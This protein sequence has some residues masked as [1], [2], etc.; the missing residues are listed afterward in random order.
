MMKNDKMVVEGSVAGDMTYKNLIN[1]SNVVKW[2]LKFPK[3]LWGELKLYVGVISV[4]T[5]SVFHLFRNSVKDCSSNLYL[6]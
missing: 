6:F 4:T 2:N 5:L 3:I 1:D